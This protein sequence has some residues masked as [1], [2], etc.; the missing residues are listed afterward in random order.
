MLKT[1]TAIAITAV[2][3]VSATSLAAA[4]SM[5]RV[6]AG[7]RVAAPAL[8]QDVHWEYRH[9]HRV[10]VPDHRRAYGRHGN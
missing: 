8:L 9:H 1:F 7:S 10:W 6:D 3:S 2:L 5:A 4:A